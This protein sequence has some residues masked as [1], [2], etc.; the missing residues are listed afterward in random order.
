MDDS[1]LF[2]F[3]K[4]V[5]DPYDKIL[6][7][8]LKNVQLEHKANVIFVICKYFENASKITQN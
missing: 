8:L 2:L 1:S 5:K 4:D 7:V 3:T 6:G